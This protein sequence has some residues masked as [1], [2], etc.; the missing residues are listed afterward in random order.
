[1]WVGVVGVGWGVEVGG[2]TCCQKR[3]EAV[4]GV[5]SECRP[6]RLAQCLALGASAPAPAPAYGS[7]RVVGGHRAGQGRARCIKAF[8]K[9]N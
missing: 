7:L 3:V 4:A 6:I 9:L 8:G 1:M 2:G 5:Q